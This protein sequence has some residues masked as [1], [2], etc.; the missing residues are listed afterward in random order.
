MTTAEDVLLAAER[1]LRETEH[2][3]RDHRYLS[4][5]E[6]GEISVEALRA[7][8]GHQ[9][10][11][12]KSDVRSAANFV[13]R[14]GD[15]PYASF[16]M[17]DLTAEM[18]ARGGV[19]AIGRKLGMSTADLENFEPTAK[20]F[21]YGAYFAWLSL[22]GSAGEI[23][24]GLALNLAAWGANCQR[25]GTALRASYGFGEADTAFL[26]GF[27]GLPSFRDPALD[28]VE[29]D[30]ARGT[31]PEDIVRAVRLIQAYELMFWDAMADAAELQGQS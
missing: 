12:W 16:F 2:E 14:F 24:C 28:I 31:P 5:L 13:G 18:D 7:F 19:V 26:D 8:P 10:H 21:A 22:F 29:D 3:I 17:T 6:R 27:A 30:L 23:A 25:V 20:G 11:L 4:A 15:R 1:K 9:Y